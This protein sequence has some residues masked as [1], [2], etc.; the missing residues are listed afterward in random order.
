M[1]SI[2]PKPGQWSTQYAEVFK[3]QSVVD[4]YLFRP[5]YA[6]ETFQIL[7]NL[8]A[9]D[10][11]RR[12]L[13][14]GCGTGNL[15]RGLIDVVDQIDAVDFSAAAINRGRQLPGGDSPRLHW[16]HSPMEEAL[17]NPPYALVT[18]ASSLHWMEWH[19]VLPLFRR[20]LRPGAVL[21]MV[22]NIFPAQPWTRE[23][24]PLLA[25]YSTNK[26]FRPYDNR[27]IARHLTQRLLF[28]PL[29]ER[30]TEPVEFNQSVEAY[31]TSFHS[32]NGL[33]RDRLG[34]EQ[35]REFRDRLTTLVALYCPSGDMTL[36]YHSRVIWGIPLS[37]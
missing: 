35:A 20:L 9:S 1:S 30:E 4:D 29:G 11:P 3:D 18:A 37:P 2:A 28:Q 8:M 23:I 15:A 7:S 5:A 24:Q 19:V 36:A 26:E 25:H 6:P 10:S 13:D 12:V 31:V 34:L 32:R 16:I 17:L 33:S 14:A 22:E 27:T 21:V